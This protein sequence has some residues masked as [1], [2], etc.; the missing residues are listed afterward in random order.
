LTPKSLEGQA[1]IRA[2]EA[3]FALGVESFFFE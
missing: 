2:P 3:L 1:D